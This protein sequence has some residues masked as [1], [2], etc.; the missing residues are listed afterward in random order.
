[1]T[2]HQTDAGACDCTSALGEL[3]SYLDDALAPEEQRVIAAH[4]ESCPECHHT[5][6]FQST[7]RAVITRSVT[8]ETLPEGLIERL[9]SC[10]AVEQSEEGPLAVD[11]RRPDPDSRGS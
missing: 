7:L 11:A 6:A 2:E 10:F 4:L 1:M 9:R 5:L 8:V 3:R